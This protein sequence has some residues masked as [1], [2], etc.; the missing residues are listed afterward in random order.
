MVNF[1]EDLLKIQE[2]RQMILEVIRMNDDLGQIASL[3]MNKKYEN[4]LFSDE[5]FNQIEQNDIMIAKNHCQLDQ[6][7]RRKYYQL[8]EEYYTQYEQIYIY[9]KKV[10]DFIRNLGSKYLEFNSIEE[11]INSN[12]IDLVYKQ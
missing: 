8:I 9:Y 6:E 4:I 1:E 11:I 3:I 5:Y 12:E 7:V 10:N 2:R